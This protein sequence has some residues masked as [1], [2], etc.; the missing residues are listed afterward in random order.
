MK[1][2]DSLFD[3]ARSQFIDAS[4]EVMR[5]RSHRTAHVLDA[6]AGRHG[7][8]FC[9][10]KVIV[11]AH[12]GEKDSDKHKKQEDGPSIDPYLGHASAQTEVWSNV[13]YGMWC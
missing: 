1:A 8:G 11:K 5:H 3:T 6:R 7:L 10:A 13:G 9:G 2:T 12:D 4:R